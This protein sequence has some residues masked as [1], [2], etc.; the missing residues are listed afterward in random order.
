M[1][2]LD[3]EGNL[4]LEAWINPVAVQDTARV[5]HHYS[6]GSQYTLGLQDASLSHS[7]LVFN[8]NSDGVEIKAALLNNLAQFT[9][10]GWIKPSVLKFMALFGQ[11]D[12]II[13]CFSDSGKLV[14]RNMAGNGG[15]I[16][17][18]VYPHAANEWHHLAFVGDG[19]SLMIYI[20][21]VRQPVPS[22]SGRTTSS[23]GSS[24]YQ[25]TIGYKN[26]G[27]AGEFAGQMDEVRYWS[28][29]RSQ[30]DIREAMNRRLSG[31]ESGLIG[32]W[33]FDQIEQGKVIDR[34]GNGRHGYVVGSPRVA[35]GALKANVFFAGVGKQFRQSTV[36]IL[37]DTWQ[38]LAAVHH[39]SYALAFDGK[40]DHLTAEHT[41]T[42]SVN[43]NVTLEVFFQTDDVTVPQGLVS[44]GRLR[45]GTAEAVPYALY[46]AES[47]RLKF[48]YEDKGGTVHE[49][50]SDQA[51]AA[52]TFY[53][54]AVTRKHETE[55][56]NQGTDTNPDVKVNHVAMVNFY[57]NLVEAGNDRR[58]APTPGDNEQ[59]LEFGKLADGDEAYYLKGIV[60][61]VRLWN[62]CLELQN[63][64]R[65]PRRGRRGPGRL[66][67]IR[68][69]RRRPHP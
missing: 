48:V 22:G 66:V 18:V 60:S 32:Y 42:L 5:I 23:Y 44:K 2:K 36:P 8:G 57:I 33:T 40:D 55:V 31:P 50:Q 61:E 45:D 37:A 6:D 52:G 63:I 12:T 24:A 41:T 7:A 16:G 62:T 54:V 29:A 3:A 10:E 30:S 13:S 56:K 69:E 9:L 26:W 39:Q 43:R 35:P 67:A 20:D 19:K 65:S 46:V 47:G 14:I 38:H 25:T 4:T 21:G 58:L 17:S 28:I 27:G 59:T 68:R 51:L 11:Y 53:R 1:A 49:F 64:G 34:S 15:A